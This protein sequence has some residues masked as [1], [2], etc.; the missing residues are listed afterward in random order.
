M[1]ACEINKHTNLDALK[2]LSERIEE[3]FNF[4]EEINKLKDNATSL[5][6][7]LNDI[8]CASD[9]EVSDMLNKVLTPN[10]DT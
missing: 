6:S 4:V 10:S 5:Q 3:E 9:E 1:S 7:K 8:S 2:H